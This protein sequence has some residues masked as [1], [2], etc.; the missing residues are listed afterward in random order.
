MRASGFNQILFPRSLFCL[1]FTIINFVQPKHDLPLT[2]YEFLA[3]R[4]FQDQR[5]ME[6]WSLGEPWL[7]LILIRI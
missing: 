6:N 4:D 2:E 1:L 3:N 7:S 5:L